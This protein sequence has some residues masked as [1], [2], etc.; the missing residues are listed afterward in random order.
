MI[1]KIFIKDLSANNN[2][3]VEANDI[4]HEIIL[5]SSAAKGKTLFQSQCASCHALFK[6]IEGLALLGIEDRGPWS[7][8]R[9]L[10]KW[11]Q[12]PEAFMKA[13]A[14]AKALKEKFKTSMPSFPYMTLE[15]VNAIADYLKETAG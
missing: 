10:L 3:H 11:I 13:N 6:H 15:N 4:S 14:Y 2:S 9:Q 8:R 1:N 7:D 12:N 5:S